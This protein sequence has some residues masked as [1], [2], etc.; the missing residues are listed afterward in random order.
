MYFFILVNL[1]LGFLLQT[2]TPI[3]TFL[4]SD[5]S[6]YIGCFLMLINSTA[7][8]FKFK[9]IHYRLRY[10]LFAVGS[11]LVW[12]AYWPPFFRF[13]SPMFDYF[14]LYF[15]LITAFFSLVFITKPENMDPDATI[16]LQWLSDSG[17]FNPLF[18]M[19]AV[20]VGLAMP[21]HFLLYPAAMTILVMRFTLASCMDNE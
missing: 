7:T 9:K 19:I 1:S 17:R 20:M 21:G 16:F 3:H 12:F 13:G 5:I 15:A 2:E 10:D 6:L 4:L 11:L 14:P 18:I 8:G